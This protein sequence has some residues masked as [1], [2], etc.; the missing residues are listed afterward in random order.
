MGGSKRASGMRKMERVQYCDTTA[1][2]EIQA[3]ERK[4]ERTPTEENSQ[5][6]IWGHDKSICNQTCKGQSSTSLFTAVRA[7]S[8][9]YGP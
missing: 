6:R 1:V 8:A 3:V 7:V 4:C 5:S 9:D 2:P